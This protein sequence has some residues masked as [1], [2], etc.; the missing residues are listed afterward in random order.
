MNTAASIATLP[1]VRSRWYRSVGAVL[2]GLLLNGVLSS[3]TD[4]L[5]VAIG[6]FPPLRDFGNPVAY[7]DSLLLLALIYRTVFG[8]LGCYVTA[9]LA[10]SRPMAHALALG[11]L[12]VLVGTLGAIAAW[13]TWTHWYSLAIIAVTLPSS[14]LGARIFLGRR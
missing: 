12:G 2:A 3:A 11:G 4:M 13:D 8:V 14:W 6:V 5:L 10:A 9:R 1:V 7:S